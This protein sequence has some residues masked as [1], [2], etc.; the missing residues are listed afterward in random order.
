[1][2]ST[3][4]YQNNFHILEIL[5]IKLKTQRLKKNKK[6]QFEQFGHLILNNIHLIKKGQTL[7]DVPNIFT[8]NQDEVRIQLNPKLNAQK[9]A[10][11]YYKKSS[12]FD[13]N[14]KEIEIRKLNFEKKA[15]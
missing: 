4:F 12:S 5:W 7:L 13:K 11:K 6:E 2:R 15:R 8:I 1:M 3:R 14:Q 10:E 9:N